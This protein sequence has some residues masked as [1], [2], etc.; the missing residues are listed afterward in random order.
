MKKMRFAKLLLTGKIAT[1]PLLIGQ[2]KADVTPTVSDVIRNFGALQ[3]LEFPGGAI[4]LNSIAA[5]AGSS[6]GSSAYAA[7]ICTDTNLN[8][9]TPQPANLTLGINTILVTNVQAGDNVIL[10]AASNKNDPFHLVIDP[11]LTLGTQGLTIVGSA[12]VGGGLLTPSPS[13]S[14][15]GSKATVLFPVFTSQLAGLAVGGKLYI[16]AAVI[17]SGAEVP[18]SSWRFSELDEIL[19]GPCGSAYE[20]Y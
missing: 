4:R 6:Y 20:P 3:V 19:V 9:S 16:Q 8:F 14:S 7:T 10:A 5:D 17:P 18:V 1:L 13:F 11:R 15:S 12:S 2:A